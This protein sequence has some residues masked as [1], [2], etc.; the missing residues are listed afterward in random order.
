MGAYGTFIIHYIR[1]KQ[2]GEVFL[3][4]NQ[5]TSTKLEYRTRRGTQQ[6]TRPT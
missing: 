3:T 6:R 5:G 4:Y 1:K 2:F